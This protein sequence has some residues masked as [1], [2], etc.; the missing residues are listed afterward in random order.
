[1]FL[2]NIRISKG[3]NRSVYPFT[4]PAIHDLHQVELTS[5]VTLLVGE[6]G[7]GKS[8]FLEAVAAA[9]GSVTVGA[10]S[11]E[12]DP[13][14]KPARELSKSLHLTW[15]KRTRK[16]FFLRSEDFFNYVKRL[17]EI[18][19]EMNE[20]VL[21]IRSTQ[22]YGSDYARR[23][24]LQPYQRS[25]QEMEERYG[26]DLD[27][28]SHGESF[29]KLFQARFLPG[30]LYLLDE[31]E[32]ALSPMRQ[33]AFICMIKEAVQQNAQFI[34]ATHSPVLLA[35]P[36]AQIL[37][38]DHLPPRAVDYEELE[39]IQF[40]KSFLNHKEAFLRHL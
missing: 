37:S 28:N 15:N 6:N 3:G 5:D 39:H 4:V 18:R 8:T 38:F 16:G 1:M 9:V 2:R 30:G 10:S 36:G 21:R 27:A 11:V 34:V 13:T 40:M 32:A 25:L 33:L 24:A 35:Y 31:P 26:G 7:S 20:D 29:I 17:S 19:A 14:L 23:L 12:T 22:E